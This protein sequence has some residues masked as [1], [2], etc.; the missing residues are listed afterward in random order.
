MDSTKNT[1]NAA[2][3][4]VALV[5]A[6]PPS[7][8]S[9][10]EYGFHFARA[11]Q[12]KAQVSKLSLIADALPSSES[13]TEL[14]MS[15]ELHRV[16][17]FNDPLSAHKIN[18]KL[19]DLKPDAVIFNLQFA[20]FGDR[21]IPASL[22]LFAPWLSKRKRP[23]ITLLHN[24]FET[25]DLA[26]AGF[27]RNPLIDGLTQMAGSFFTHVL[28]K[29]DALAVTMPRYQTILEEKYKASNV[30]HA[31]HG[32]FEAPGNIEALPEQPTV[33]TFGKFGTYKKV[34]LLLQAHA[35]LLKRDPTVRLVIAGSDS[36]NAKGYLADAQKRYADLP[37]VTFFGY[38]AE[39][40]V[41][42]VFSDATVVA[43]PYESTTGSSGVLHQAGQFGRA[44]VMPRIGD[45]AD[46][47]QDE[48]YEAQFFE[49]S[50]VESLMAALAD[51]LFNKEKA[52]LL[53]EANHK[54][55]SLTLSEVSE[56]YLDVLYSLQTAQ[57]RQWTSKQLPQRQ[58]AP[59]T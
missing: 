28:L 43:F 31:P 19:N 56:R 59:T 5:S 26:G 20:S 4:H 21:R 34:D 2:G 27:A 48:G 49:P 24:L 54:A 51:V 11:L 44:A 25:V 45:L 10:N 3:L 18:Q 53:G 39:E 12:E 8:G 41:P 37:N 30:F 17:S 58:D 38:V 23:T 35:Q 57:E 14:D 7:K 9:L 33:M 46:L 1:A 6:F 50:N 52:R 29:S 36:P 22:G 42:K 32:S 15:V 16:W 40:D 55:S 13:L 47:V